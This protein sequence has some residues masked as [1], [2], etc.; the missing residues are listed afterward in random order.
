MAMTAEANDRPLLTPLDATRHW[1]LD[2]GPV[3]VAVLPSSGAIVAVA[4]VDNDNIACKLCA[5][6]N[7]Q[8]SPNRQLKV[9]NIER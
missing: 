7:M 9:Q 1:T 5:A 4:D 8:K 6:L 2:T 3:A